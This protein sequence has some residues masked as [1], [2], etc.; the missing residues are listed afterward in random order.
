MLLF[1]IGL[2]NDVNA[3]A[4]C[5]DQTHFD[6]TQMIYSP[7]DPHSSNPFIMLNVQSSA[8]GNLTICNGT[9]IGYSIYF[10][11]GEFPA[12]V[13]TNLTT[14]ISGPG[15]NSTVINLIDN[16]NSSVFY[17]IGYAA[18]ANSGTYN[19][20][21]K[22][23]GCPD[24]SISKTLLV[25]PDPLPNLGGNKTICTPTTI[26]T[27]SGGGTYLWN[28]GA[29]TPSITSS[30]GIYTVTVTA[31]NGCQRAEAL[32]ISSPTIPLNLGEDK[33][34]CVSNTSTVLNTNVPSA[35]FTFAWSASSGAAPSGN[36]PTVAPTTTTTY[37]VTVTAVAGGCRAIESIVVFVTPIPVPNL[38]TSITVCQNASPSIIAF[39]PNVGLNQYD[40]TE[41]GSFY[42]S[43]FSGT[44]STINPAVS[45]TTI[46]KVTVTTQGG[47]TAADDITV[48]VYPAVTAEIY[49]NGNYFGPRKSFPLC[50]GTPYIFNGV[51]STGSGSWNITLSSPGGVTSIVSGNNITLTPNIYQSTGSV[52]YTVT[53]PLSGCEASE[54]FTFYVGQPPSLSVGALPGTQLNCVVSSINITSVVSP[55]TPVNPNAIWFY[56]WDKDG[57][58][59]PG[60]NVTSLNVTSSGYYCVSVADLVTRSM[61]VGCM[62]SSCI[63]ITQN[64]T[65]PAISLIATPSNTICRATQMTLTANVIGSSPYTYLWSTGANTSFISGTPSNSNTYTVTVTGANGC[66]S[67]RSITITVLLAPTVT[68]GTDVTLTCQ[69]PT[70][71]LTATPGGGVSP[72]SYIW[73]RNGVVFPNGT[74]ITT[75]GQTGTYCVTVTGFNG[76]ISSSCVLVTQSI[77]PPTVAL[78]GTNSTLNCSTLSST[79]SANITG[80]VSPYTNSWTRNGI[81]FTNPSNTTIVSQPGT[82]CITVTGANGCKS[83][84]CFVLSQNTTAPAASLSASS[85]TLTCST[86]SVT[87]IATPIGGVSPF[88]HSWTRNGLL[89]GLTSNAIAVSTPGNYC[90]T[91]TGAN[92][93]TSSACINILQS[94]DGPSAS[95]TASANTITCSTASS[96][97]TANATGGVSPFTYSWTR[98][99]ISFT[100][101]SN[102]TTVSQQGI[103]CVTITGINGCSRSSCITIFQNA[104]VPTTGITSSPSVILT[105]IVPSI[106]LTATGGGT[107]IWT[108]GT[109]GATR[110]VSSPGSYCVTVTG[111]N[112]C[113]STNCITISQNIVTPTVSVTALNSTL[114]CTLNSIT[115]IASPGGALASSP[116][117]WSRNGVN[118]INTTNTTTIT[119]P[120]IYC[121][122]VSGANGCTTSSC[123][124]IFQNATIPTAGIT[125][126]PNTT[127]TCSVPSITLTATGGGTYIWTG[128][129]T[130]ATRT[131]NAPGTYCVT[132]TGSNGCTSSTCITIF[133]NATIPATG[134]TASPNTTLTCSVPSITLTA[135]GGGTYIWTG[136]ITGATRTVNAPGT[137]CVTVTGTNGCTSSSCITIFQN[138]TIPATGITAS[139]NTTLTCSVPSITLTATG[140]GTYIWTGGITGAT[141]TVNAPGTYCVTVTGTNGCTSSTCITIF[142]NATIP[143]TGITASPNTTLTCSVPSITL[144]ATGG[145]T[146]IWTG[147]ITGATRTVNAP[148]TYCV[149]VTGTNGCTAS[150]CITIFQNATVPTTGIT[151]S[152]SVILTCIVPSITLTATGG[153]H[154][155]GQVEQQERHVLFLHQ[156]AI[157]L[158]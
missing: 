100:N 19:F 113:T 17:T 124:T 156:E 49:R 27:A 51:S 75:I 30:I 141:R 81:S 94:I 22:T 52:N 65:P 137:Y 59:I 131:V 98:N 5:P 47:C 116:Y 117:T 76:C 118:F 44:S 145:G 136:G 58:V 8:D 2:N 135:T 70:N 35:G 15:Y 119:Q 48:N 154:I 134:I 89:L 13:G 9:S 34:V 104:T 40:W 139:P 133:Q 66:S 69:K 21:Y 79:L 53:D 158:L 84:S 97:L 18:V 12:L 157:A 73:T 109:T 138:A 3:A 55:A 96:T 155:Y 36:T 71:D 23:V 7:M 82:Y 92:G 80:G 112:G 87:I 33:Y 128:G 16:F 72:Y 126:S 67:T 14:V 127:L 78:T 61:T 108:G 60:S 20:I 1:N 107:Y 64:T 115:I 50:I 4:V 140:G 25:R 77:N 102:I 43:E 29:T 56:R 105:C 120:G 148:G 123:I 26:T 10:D 130:G 42:L 103:Y 54:L 37:T 41:N 68:L 88:T 121:V 57:V 86:T 101:A 99:G 153:A 149:T 28:T 83:S 74:N 93:C 6:E 122:T 11:L 45:N 38:P 114:T 63:S 132:V 106:T 95:L 32:T 150:S 111:L 146:Y 143:A 110:T 90:V 39:G 24:V 91:I 46:Y 125:A 31:A 147:G 62:N 142:Q 152:P 129:I 85:L 144:T 151:S